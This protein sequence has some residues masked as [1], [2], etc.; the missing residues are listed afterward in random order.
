[1]RAAGG[2]E[3]QVDKRESSCLSDR[4]E[5]LSTLAL[6]TAFDTEVLEVVVNLL[7][8]LETDDMATIATDAISGNR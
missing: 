3:A 8:L 7:E 2:D 6:S 5:K 4:F 1:M